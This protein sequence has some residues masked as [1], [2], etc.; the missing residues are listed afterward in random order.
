MVET[1]ENLIPADVELVGLDGN[2]FSIMGAVIKGLKAAGNGADIV[3]AYQADAMSGDYEYL[4][5]VSVAYTTN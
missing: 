5:Q 3:D 2:A 1:P 4:L